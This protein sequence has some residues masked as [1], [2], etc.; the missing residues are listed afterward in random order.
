[1]ASAEFATR[2]K[3]YGK[4]L[5]AGYKIRHTKNMRNAVDQ[6]INAYD[7]CLTDAVATRQLFE[8]LADKPVTD[9]DVRAYFLKVMEA[10]DKA[11]ADEKAKAS[12]IAEKRMENRLDE[13]WQIWNAP[14]NQT[15]TRGTA[16]AALNTVIEYADFY[17]ATRVTEGTTEESQR[18]ESAMFGSGDNLKSKATVEALELAGV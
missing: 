16:F 5:H 14:T 3:L 6:A 11:E 12:K 1:M 8:M 13:L 2:R 10:A 15:G 7:K 4:S 17:R 18:F 9:A